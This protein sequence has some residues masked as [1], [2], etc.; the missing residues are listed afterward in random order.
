MAWLHTTSSVNYGLPKETQLTGE[1]NLPG[2]AR[3]FEKMCMSGLSRYLGTDGHP[4]IDSQILTQKLLLF[5]FIFES[6]Q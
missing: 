6:D 5:L 4:D 3:R 1:R 2:T